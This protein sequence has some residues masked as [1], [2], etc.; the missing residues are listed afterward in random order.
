MTSAT[1]SETA[2]L[3]ANGM[4]PQEALGPFDR[5][6]TIKLIRAAL[7][8][9][10][11]KAWSVTGGRGTAWGW[12]EIQSPP[13]RRVE[14]GYMTDAD[15]A[16]L[17]ELLGL[18]GPVHCQGQSIPASSAYRREYIARAQGQVPLTHG[19]PYWD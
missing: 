1:M 11:G 8:R 5:D 9:R 12:I 14:Y 18:G 3:I 17:G 7:R 19:T 16:E 2:E 6:E 10:S 13:K 4:H 15:R